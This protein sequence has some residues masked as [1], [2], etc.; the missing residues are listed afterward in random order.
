[1][2]LAE[3]DVKTTQLTPWLELGVVVSLHE[4]RRFLASLTPARPAAKLR[5]IPS[6]LE[7]IKASIIFEIAL[8]CEAMMARA[9][10]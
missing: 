6:L 7:G 9:T 2:F 4:D 8:G 5:R 3:F 10:A 1:V